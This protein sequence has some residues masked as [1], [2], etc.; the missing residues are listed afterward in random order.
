MGAFFREKIKNIF[1]TKKEI[2]DIGGGLRLLKDRGNR[3][4][5]NREWIR[6]YLD[7]VRYRIL[8]PV[9]DYNPDIVGDIHAL[10]LENDSIDAVICIAVLEHVENPI[11]ACKEILRVLR[12]GGY[13]FLYLP[14]L[15]Y[16]HAKPGYYPDHWRYT[17]DSIRFLTKGFSEVEIQNVRGAL[18]TWIY[19]SPLGRVRL[20]PLLARYGDRLFK[21]TESNQTSGYHVFLVK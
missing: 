6:P 20:F 19:L 4:D 3:Y 15:Y 9:P 5:S 21:K 11:Q 8:D 16:Y 18:E 1:E 13:C 10:P 17:R 7:T 12:P 14:F 2:L